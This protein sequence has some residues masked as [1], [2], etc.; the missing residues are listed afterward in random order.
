MTPA[1]FDALATLIGLRQSTSREAARLVLVDGLSVLD[2]AGQCGIS[3]QGA[4]QAVI[5]CRKALELAKA[6]TSEPVPPR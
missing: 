2:A 3:A 1:Q 5:R 6:A 4:N